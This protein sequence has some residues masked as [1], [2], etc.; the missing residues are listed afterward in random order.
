V[1]IPDDFHEIMDWQPPITLPADDHDRPNDLSSVLSSLRLV[2][3]LS[4]STLAWA[5]CGFWAEYAVLTLDSEPYRRAD[6][7]SSQDL[8]GALGVTSEGCGRSQTPCLYVA[9]WH[10]MSPPS[11]SW[12]FHGSIAVGRT[13]YGQVATSIAIVAGIITT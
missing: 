4:R 6:G 2:A 8:R 12:T 1:P 10:I 5:Y 7:A 9:I 13:I 11:I 3:V